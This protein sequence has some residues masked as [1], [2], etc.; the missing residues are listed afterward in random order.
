MAA[1]C[2][3]LQCLAKNGV[4]MGNSCKFSAP[5]VASLLFI[6]LALPLRATTIFDNSQNDLATRFDPGTTEVGDEILLASTE[7]YLTSFSFEYWGNNTASPTSFAGDVEA[8]VRFYENN[9]TPFN[10]YPTPAGT[11][12]FDSGWFSIGAPTSRST[13][14]FTQRLD[15]PEEGLFLPASA[16]TWSIQFEGMDATDSVGVDIYSPPTVGRDY[17]DYW[18][19]DGGW[20]LLT[21]S[22]P[23]DFAAKMD[24]NANIPEPS[25]VTLAMLGG[26][27]ILGFA[28]RLRRKQ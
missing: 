11:P 8:R 6:G 27:G 20:Q 12:F 25:A 3:L 16:I 7:R 10:G 28:N 21:N 5:L 14:N 22:L 1:C 17:P 18:E 26:L 23:M 13:F 2:T 4:P 15:F 19:N 9:G 24:A